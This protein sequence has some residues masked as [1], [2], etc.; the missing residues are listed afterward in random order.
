METREI[1]HGIIDLAHSVHQRY[2][3]HHRLDVKVE[4]QSD[5]LGMGL[6]IVIDAAIPAGAL[7][8]GRLDGFWLG[9]LLAVDE[10][11][12]R[13]EKNNF[14]AIGPINDHHGALYIPYGAAQVR[15]T[16]LHTLALSVHILDPQTSNTTEIAQASCKIALTPQHPWKRVEFFLPLIRLCMA[17]IRV[18]NEILPAEIRGLREYFTSGL[19]LRP[20]DMPDLRLAMRDTIH[21]DPRALLDS[22]RL[23]MPMLTPEGTLEI[24]CIVAR[25][26]GPINPHEQALLRHVADL[27]AIPPARYTALTAAPQPT[28]ALPR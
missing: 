7:L 13:D 21:E 25:L 23:R 27:L 17:M 16:G 2:K 15:S 19:A 14:L 18:D 22:L 28:K 9:P 12:F 24:L 1:L 10:V 11:L 4:Q 5:N 8:F 26:D 20:E 3:Q 6:R